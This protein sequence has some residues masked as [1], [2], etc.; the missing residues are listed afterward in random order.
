MNNNKCESEDECFDMVTNNIGSISVPTYLITKN[1][2]T[3]F[4]KS[5]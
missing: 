1:V 4:C 5:V 3:Y 2:C